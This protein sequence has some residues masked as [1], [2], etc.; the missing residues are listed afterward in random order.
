MAA[1]TGSDMLLGAG[2]LHGS[3]ILSYEQ[4][5]L[6]CE[7]YSIV[8]KMMDGIVVNEETLALDAIRAAGPGG[9]FLT[10]KHTRAHM[11]ELWRPRL[12]DRRPY[13]AWEADP[14]GARQAAGERARSLLRSH[15]PTPLDPALAAELKAIIASA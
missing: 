8:H 6:D 3:R 1:L 14:S 11:R 4:M 15:S 10:Q 9:H 13:D 7:I 5:V 2:L 12:L